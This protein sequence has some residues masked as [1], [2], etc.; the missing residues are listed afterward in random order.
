MEKKFLKVGKSINF[1]FNT[2][3]LEC[4]LTPGMVYNIDIDHYTDAIS[5]E[6]TSGLS[7]PSK[8][9]C[10]QR[11]ERFIDKVINSYNL[12]ESGFTGVML[13]GL[14]GSGKTVMAKIIANKSSLPII[15][16]DKSIRPYILK[17]LVEKLGDTSVCFLFDELD[18]VLADYD[19]SVLLQVLDGSDTKGKHM[20][21]FTCN[22]DREIS[23]YLI[24]R[25]SRI[26]YWR[27]FKEMSPSLIMEVL[28]DKLN[29][30]KEIKSLTDF[31]KDNFE[32]CS[33]DNISSF[34]KEA[35]DY[36]TTTFEEL[37]EDMNL[38]SK[39][40]VKPHSRSCKAN[41]LKN[42]KKK[43]ASDDI[44]CDCCCAGC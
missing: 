5:L 14:K 10:T 31:I 40:T 44:C 20:I 24:D 27:E 3:G 36:P 30:K 8:V 7:L 11:D 23:E 25:C 22:D 43:A 32:V 9:Y 1:K 12:S 15:N 33:F 6:E 38:S 37:F 28:N 42:V 34:V 13:A 39:G 26:R 41:C 19:D 18:K 4:D 2:E 21:L 29:D 16:I 35:N 17:N